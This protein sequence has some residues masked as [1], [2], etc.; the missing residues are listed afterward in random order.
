[1]PW[2]QIELA[3]SV[4]L[5]KASSEQP[6][7]VMAY[8]RKKGHRENLLQCYRKEIDQIAVSKCS[9]PTDATYELWAESE[10]LKINT[11]AL[12]PLT[13]DTKYSRGASSLGEKEKRNGVPRLKFVCKTVYAPL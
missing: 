5:D 10:D 7:T 2:K 3:T 4:Q 13:Q 11:R 12:T 1:M 6:A 9:I 8:R